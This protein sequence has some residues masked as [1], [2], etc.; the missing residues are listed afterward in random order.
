MD[1]VSR[2]VD[3]SRCCSSCSG[4]RRGARERRGSPRSQDRRARVQGEVAQAAAAPRA[5]RSPGG[6][7]P[8]PRVDGATHGAHGGARPCGGAGGDAAGPD[9]SRPSE[10]AR[11]VE[12]VGGRS[13]QRAGARVERCRVHARAHRRSRRDDVRRR[14]CQRA[15]L[16]LHERDARYH[17][18]PTAES[19]LATGSGI[20][21][22]A[23]L[24]F[25]AIVKRFNVLVGSVQFYYA[26]G[27]NNHIADEAYYGGAW[28]YYD[29]TWGAFTPTRTAVCCRST[30]RAPIP[31]RGRC[32]SRT[33]PCCGAACR[34]WPAW[35]RSVPRPI[36]RPRRARQAA[37]PRALAAQRLLVRIDGRPRRSPPR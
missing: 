23:A 29:P 7:R 17:P 14:P 13:P 2:A 1:L 32:S 3:P 20:C 6:E 21:G 18:L 27:I 31:I 10:L 30:R 36:R 8:D 11:A 16:R 5:Q 24:T 4:R 9:R 19:A 22:N 25:A 37:V 33:T 26:D 34:R 12:Q 28:H 15:G 35:R